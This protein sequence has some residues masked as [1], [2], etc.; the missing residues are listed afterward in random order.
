MKPPAP[1]ALLASCCL[2]LLLWGGWPQ[3]VWAQAFAPTDR[4]R[5]QY[6]RARELFAAFDTD[7]AED[8]LKALEVSYQNYD[9]QNRL[10]ASS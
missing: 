9:G 3:A 4:M 5:Q 2:V 8:V 1:S 10:K 7:G 6:Q